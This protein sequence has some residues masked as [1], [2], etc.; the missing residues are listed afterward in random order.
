M[1]WNRI[2]AGATFIWL[3][4]L[5]CNTAC[6]LI[7]LT[8]EPSP[9]SLPPSIDRIRELAELT[10][11][12]ILASEVVE[13]SV[14]GHAGSVIVI[15]LIHGT[16]TLG[17][18]LEQA[19]FLQVDEQSQHLVLGLPRPSVRRVAIDH[20][21]TRVLSCERYGLWRLAV[22]TALED[23]A[24]AKSLVIGHAMLKDAALRA[25]HAS[26]ARNHAQALLIRFVESLG[27]TLAI[28]WQ[29]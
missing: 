24:F 7:A 3:G 22:G 9:A 6:D 14:S 4:L 21:R 12:E 28:Q 27:W 18:D 2:L 5:L 29:D 17:I 26:R 11:T 15:A 25:E 13:G 19:R 10:V 1:R 20:H 23:R 8:P 16:A